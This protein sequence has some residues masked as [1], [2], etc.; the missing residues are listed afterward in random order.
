VSSQTIYSEMKNAD[1]KQLWAF[2]QE[3]SELRR[4]KENEIDT[5]SIDWND[6]NAIKQFLAESFKRQMDN[7]NAAAGKELSRIFGVTEES[8]DIIIEPVDFSEVVWESGD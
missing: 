6:K 5:S 1:N 3:L 4:K 8:Q 7:G 2:A